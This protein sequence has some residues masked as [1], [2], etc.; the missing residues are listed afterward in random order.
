MNISH[1]HIFTAL[2]NNTRLPRNLMDKENEYQNSLNKILEMLHF[3]QKG[4]NIADGAPG[5]YKFDHE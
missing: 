1:E 5:H 3:M 2:K 4:T